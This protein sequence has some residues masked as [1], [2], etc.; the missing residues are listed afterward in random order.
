MKRAGVQ[1][2]A[3]L[4]RIII[5]TPLGASGNGAPQIQRRRNT[6]IGRYTQTKAAVRKGAIC[7][8]VVAGVG[9]IATR[10]GGPARVHQ[11]SRLSARPLAAHGGEGGGY[12]LIHRHADQHLGVFSAIGSLTKPNKSRLLL[13]K[14]RGGEDVDSVGV[15]KAPP[16]SPHVNPVHIMASSSTRVQC[17]ESS[18]SGEWSVCCGRCA[19]FTRCLVSAIK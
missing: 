1:Q 14:G 6:R 3:P 10:D 11:N 19:P 8:C 18:T 4:R 13:G 12:Q 7:A 9:C 2:R 15:C 16:S 5:Y 17:S